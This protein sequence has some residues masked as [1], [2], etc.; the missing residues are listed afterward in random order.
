MIKKWGRTLPEV[1]KRFIKAP[2]RM[3][4]V[5]SHLIIKELRCLWRR[6]F[7][8]IF[9]CIVKSKNQEM[10]NVAGGIINYAW[11]TAPKS[12]GW[13][14]LIMMHLSITCQTITVSKSGFFFLLN[15]LDFSPNENHACLTIIPYINFK[16]T[17]T[18]SERIY[19][20]L[21]IHW[22]V[23]RHIRSCLQY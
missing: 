19:L 18:K 12:A 9:L 16:P 22:Q 6:P 23:I 20:S 10:N 13:S 21:I 4:S 2:Y 8:V 3:S 15:I 11:Q 7:V 1:K 5:F 17:H 14:A